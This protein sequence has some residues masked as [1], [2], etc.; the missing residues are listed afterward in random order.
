MGHQSPTQVRHLR[1]NHNAS[2]LCWFGLVHL[3]FLCFRQRHTCSLVATSESGYPWTVPVLAKPD[4]LQRTP[5]S[6]WLGDSLPVNAI[7]WVWRRRCHCLSPASRIWRG[8][9]ARKNSRRRVV[10]VQEE[11]QSLGWQTEARSAEH[12]LA[13][14]TS[15]AAHSQKLIST[16]SRIAPELPA[17]WQ[18]SVNPTAN[19]S[20]PRTHLLGCR[21][22]GLTSPIRER[23]TRLAKALLD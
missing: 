18:W 3:G 13:P 1:A 16:I 10:P 12:C 19:Y 8:S 9:V 21:I 15:Y 5:Y 6:G 20:L 4:V 23:D 7:G 14:H 2:R 11:C 22:C 17:L